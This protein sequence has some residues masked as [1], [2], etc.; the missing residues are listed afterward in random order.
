MTDSVILSRIKQ[1]FPHEP[2][3]GQAEALRLLAEFLASREAESAFV[4]RGYAGTGK[5]SLVAAVVRAAV[6]LRQPVV[7]LAPTG[8]AARRLAQFSGHAAYTIHRWIYR[9]QTFSG[10]ETPF[11][12]SPNLRRHMLFVV[13][14]ASLISCR[15]GASGSL[16]GSGALLDD[17]V[18]FVYGSEGCRLLFTGDS[19]QLPPVGEVRSPALDAGWLS[20]YGL[21]VAE[22]ELR[23]VV[24][25]T[26]ESGILWNAT[27]LR[28]LLLEGADAQ[29]LRL[30]ASGFPDV[31]ALPG[32]ELI[33]A[34]SDSYARQG[35]EETIILTRSNKRAVLYNRGIRTTVLDLED[36]LCSGDRIMIARNHYYPPEPSAGRAATSDEKMQGFSE[37]ALPLSSESAATFRKPESAPARMDFL[38]NGDI[39]VVR[40][41]RR[42]RSLYG[43]R[44]ADVT[45]AFPDY[46]DC[47]RDEILMLDTLQSEAP[48]LSEADSER[49]FEALLE[50][51]QDLPRKAD[52]MKQLRENPY[53]N[54]LQ[55][56]YGYAVTCH[57]A[58]GGQ[59][60]DVYIDVGYVPPEQQDEGYLRWLY[61]ALTRATRRVYLVNF[62]AGQ[63]L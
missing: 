2:T 27:L 37:K 28:N 52:R 5:S 61:T 56:K 50:D 35:V 32:S 48:S 30:K 23:Q 29:G 33:E 31:V 25:Q 63:L 39:A 26:A 17:L 34:L 59:W 7:L 11:S 13:D 38:A 62:P 51:Y 22:A 41:V 46:D 16:F 6:S 20:G 1:F 42:E 47:E 43:F 18:R 54:A 44:F 55:A 53:Y 36:E 57:K 15:P 4:L 60:A 8:R 10:R 3:S 58:Q 12:L 21:H 19:A 49:F 14:E 9:Q 24:R 45:L 40:R